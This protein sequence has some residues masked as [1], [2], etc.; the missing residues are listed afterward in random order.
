MSIIMGSLVS[1]HEQ[2]RSSDYHQQRWWR[3][4]NSEP[5][6]RRNLLRFD[7]RRRTY[8]LGSKQ[9]TVG[10]NNLSTT[11][12]GVIEDH[13]RGGG[14]GGSL[15]KV[16]TG[17]LTLTGANT[18]S[19]GT[20]INQGAIAVNADTGLGAPNGPAHIQRRHSAFDSSFDLSSSRVITLNG[21]SGGFVGGGTIDTNDFTRRSHRRSRVLAALRRPASAPSF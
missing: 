1:D 6:N 16:G 15:V 4:Q 14:V 18:Y 21:A 9:L 5:D 19:G 2:R 20:T 11:V 7:C 10:S 13:F 12:N 3:S 8:N 17:T